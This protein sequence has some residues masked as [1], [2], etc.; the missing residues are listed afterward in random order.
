MPYEYGDQNGNQH[1]YHDAE[2]CRSA[3]VFAVIVHYNR[4]ISHTGSCSF[5]VVAVP[6]YTQPRQAL[7]L[8]TRS[9]RRVE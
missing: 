2:R 9:M 1:D 6:T 4:A 5:R 7:M 8:L 3:P